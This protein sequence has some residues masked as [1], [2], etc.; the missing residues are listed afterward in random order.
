MDSKKKYYIACG[1]L[2]VFLIV[3]KY[4]LTGCFVMCM[5]WY[6]DVPIY[7]DPIDNSE[8]ERLG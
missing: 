2:A 6:D 8:T 7:M 5:D 1:V 3:A 4:A